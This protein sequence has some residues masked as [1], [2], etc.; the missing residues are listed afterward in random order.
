MIHLSIAPARR[1][2]RAAASGYDARSMQPVEEPILE[3]APL[4]W[5]LA[6]QL[7]RKD[8]ATG[9]NCAWY[10]RFW[11]ILR[12]MGLGGSP[13]IHAEFY[14]SALGAASSDG[15]KLRILISGAAD[16]SMLAHVL[17]A[18]GARNPSPEITVVDI[19]ETPLWL[20]RWYAARASCQIETHS[21]DIS[22]FEAA[23]PFDAI[24]THSFFGQI[25]EDKRPGLL[26]AWQRLLRPGGV[27]IT[28]DRV[29]PASS[30]DPVRFST[31]QAQEFCATVRRHAEAMRETLQIDPPELARYA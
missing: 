31:N 11:Q 25:P 22:E 4:A 1:S 9:E 15:N 2:T 27:A 5:H 12:L 30:G 10:H 7:C 3:S 28:A 14:R 20:N 23:R 26:S 24:C 13:A 19:C 18:L 21:S 6:P 17:A 16:Y 8:S 29:R